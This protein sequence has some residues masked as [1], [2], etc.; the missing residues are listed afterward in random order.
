MNDDVNKVIKQARLFAE[1][2]ERKDYVAAR[3]LLAPECVYFQLARDL[4]GPEN[5]VTDYER[6][7]QWGI[8][9]FDSIERESSVTPTEE[10]WALLTFFYHIRHKGKSLKIRSEQII[11]LDETGRIGRIEHVELASQAN[12]LFQFYLDVGL[13]S[14]TKED[15]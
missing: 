1:A 2:L 6:V 5:I 10:G 8:D 9:Q 14:K 13:I 12:A 11:E 4:R 7:G 3:A 15:L